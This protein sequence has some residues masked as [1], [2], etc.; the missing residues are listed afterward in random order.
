MLFVPFIIIINHH[1]LL[2]NHSNFR[3]HLSATDFLYCQ[4]HD[5]I[6]AGMKAIFN[7]IPKG[8]ASCPVRQPVSAPT[9]TVYLAAE[10]TTWDFFPQKNNLCTGQLTDDQSVFV[11]QTPTTIGSKYVKAVF[12]AYSAKDF[13]TAI[14]N[15]PK[16][17]FMGPTIELSVGESVRVV[18]KNKLQWP[19]NVQP[20]GLQTNSLSVANPGQT[21]EYI[22]WADEQS[23]PTANDPS[24]IAWLYR[25]T[26]N[27][28]GD[29]QAGLYGAV[30]V[31]GPR[32]KASDFA[33]QY[34]MGFSISN[35]NVSPLLSKN[36]NKYIT[37][38]FDVDVESE[39]FQESNMMH[40]VNGYVYCNAPEFTASVNETV[41]WHLLSVGSELDLHAVTWRD[42]SVVMDGTR[43]F[44]VDMVPG[45]TRTVDMKAHAGGKT[46]IQ[47]DVTDHQ[48]AG[49]QAI[50]RVK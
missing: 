22:W 30:I 42:Y 8:S 5:H 45:E 7:V 24:S 46:L 17:G 38:P 33:R 15:D 21:V 32:W 41:R 16:I 34:V 4:V 29:E 3:F 20:G 11:Q 48:A 6:M 10:E 49:M 9:R 50:F 36:V 14:P 40:A 44:A 23:G 47:C 25:S 27:S 43:R 19:V 2:D 18:L 26:A 35:E 1:L 28:P 39:E 12:R 31:R 37:N 13:K